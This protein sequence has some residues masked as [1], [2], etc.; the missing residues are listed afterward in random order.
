MICLLSGVLLAEDLGYGVHWL[1]NILIIA[2]VIT[3][4]FII[5]IDLT[6]TQK[7]KFKKSDE[8][9]GIKYKLYKYHAERYWAIFVAGILIWFW[10]I[11]YPWSPPIAFEKAL[12]D[13][14]KIHII[15]VTA[16]QWF[17]Q[18]SDGGVRNDEKYT[19][20]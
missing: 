9:E 10:I 14:S 15:H 12:S 3:T 20:I 13:N 4:G 1:V 11:G 2:I 19:E 5:F 8:K 18:F 6:I 17:W 16:G 7:Y